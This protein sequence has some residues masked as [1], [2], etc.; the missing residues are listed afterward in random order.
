MT[1]NDILRVKLK[2]KTRAL[3]KAS[4]Y[5]KDYA[6]GKTSKQVY[7]FLKIIAVNELLKE[8]LTDE[9]KKI[10]QKFYK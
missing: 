9:D 8:P 6:N 7:E 10:L 3:W 1:R 5:L 4:E 2:V